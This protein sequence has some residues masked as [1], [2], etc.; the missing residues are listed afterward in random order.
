MC[1][2]EL[3]IALALCSSWKSS[4]TGKGHIY[5]HDLE[6]FFYILMDMDDGQA[7]QRT[8]PLATSRL[9]R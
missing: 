5:Q 9:R 2:V 1:P 3:A 4:V 6:S 8:R 7:R